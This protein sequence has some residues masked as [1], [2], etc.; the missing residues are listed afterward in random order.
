MHYN[1]EHTARYAALLTVTSEG[2]ARALRIY[3]VPFA[4]LFLALNAIFIWTRVCV[5]GGRPYATPVAIVNAF[6]SRTSYP[7]FSQIL[8]SLF[9]DLGVFVS[10]SRTWGYYLGAFLAFTA[11]LVL[12][13]VGYILLFGYPMFDAFLNSPN[14][15]AEWLRWTLLGIILVKYVWTFLV[16]WCGQNLILPWVRAYTD[17]VAE[18]PTSP[19]QYVTPHEGALHDLRSPLFILA[20]VFSLIPFF[21]TE[22]LHLAFFH[23]IIRPLVGGYILFWGMRAIPWSWIAEKTGIARQALR[24]AEERLDRLDLPRGEG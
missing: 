9:F 15:F 13:A 16:C 22:S 23:G 17:M 8:Q 7:P 10:R 1:S 12:I 14:G 3:H 20:F 6:L 21:L 5:E 11:E 18:P 19:L 24:S 4:G 2:L